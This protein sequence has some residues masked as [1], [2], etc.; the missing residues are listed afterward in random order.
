MNTISIQ[1]M[2]NATRE[3]R[4]EEVEA[5]RLLKAIALHHTLDDN[6]FYSIAHLETGLKVLS[7]DFIIDARLQLEAIDP[8]LEVID[9]TL[10]KPRNTITAEDMN[11]V[12][13]LERLIERLEARLDP[14]EAVQP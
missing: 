5:I 6:K 2:D 11:A 14:V 12:K 4:S 8:I 7:V 9:A 1:V 13:T 3:I 10:N